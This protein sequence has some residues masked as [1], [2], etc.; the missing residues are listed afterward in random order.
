MTNITFT[1]NILISILQELRKNG[2]EPV[3]IG[4]CVRDKFMEIDPKDIDIEVHGCT[5]EQLDKILSR[6]GKV[7]SVGKSFGILKFKKDNLECDFSVPRKENRLGVGHKDFEVSFEPMTKEE[8]ALRRD[9]TWNALGFDPINNILFDF[10]NGL[11]DLQ[12]GIIRHTSDKFKEDSLRVLRGLQFQ[13]RFGFTVAPET[14]EVMREMS[15]ELKHL[16]KE[17][18]SEEFMKWAIK[19]KHPELIFDFLRES[20]SMVVI[21]ELGLLKD[22]EQD[23]IWH[24]EGDV[25]KHTQLTMKRMLSI[26]EREGIVEDERAKF[27]FTML[28][29]DIAKP[30]TTEHEEKGGRI[31]VTSKGHEG[32]GAV[33]AEEILNRIGIKPVLV[34]QIVK[35][36]KFHLAH[37]NIF[38]INGLSSRK[39]ALLR[40]SK[41]IHP[42][43]IKDLLFVIEADA[44]GRDNV[45]EERILKVRTEIEEVWNLAKTLHVTTEQRKSILM[46]RHLIEIGMKPGLKFGEILKKADEAQD[47]LEFT[48]LKGAKLWLNRELN[49]SIKTKLMVVWGKL[50]RW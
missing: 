9:F 33:M 5:V 7:D 35:L 6:L 15:E 49:P 1:D 39:K 48:T 4:G 31:C 37:V 22:T 40:L 3:L 10:F 50:R 24:P 38:S 18:L 28:L 43:T 25:E 36:I 2:F 47:N 20:G 46:G 21:P 27:M 42:S 8:A 32:L 16:P 14:F 17:R 13:S 34:E 12:N 26:C 29:H 30:Q 11:E 23:P 19:G 41:N 44:L 45:D